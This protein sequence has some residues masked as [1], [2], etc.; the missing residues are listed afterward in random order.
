MYDNLKKMQ[1]LSK[2]KSSLI[3]KVNIIINILI[4]NLTKKLKNP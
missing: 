2:R 1:K 4:I 3:S